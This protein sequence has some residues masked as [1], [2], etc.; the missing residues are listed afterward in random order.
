LTGIPTDELEKLEVLE[1]GKVLR[2]SGGSP[3]GNRKQGIAFTATHLLGG[4]IYISTS[5]GREP[6]E[7]RLE[8]KMVRRQADPSGKVLVSIDPTDEL[9]FYGGPVRPDLLPYDRTWTFPVMALYHGFQ[10][11]G[12]WA[13]YWWQD[14]SRIVWIDAQNHIEISPAYCGFRDGWRD[15]VLLH[16]LIQKAGRA[17]FDKLVGPQTTAAL[18]V[19]AVRD[20][21]YPNNARDVPSVTAMTNAND[22]LAVKAARRQA[23]EILAGRLRGPNGLTK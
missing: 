21:S 9:W 13:F 15:A 8:L 2:S 4:A 3:W 16:H 14:T 6:K 19:G 10:G 5:D 12:Q 22:L 7:H 20:P 23:L 17:V 18:R 1:D 11:Y